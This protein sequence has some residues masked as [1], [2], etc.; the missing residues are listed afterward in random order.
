MKTKTEA[1][2]TTHRM[3]DSFVFLIAFPI[4]IYQQSINIVDLDIFSKFLPICLKQVNILVEK[5]G[6]IEFKANGFL[7]VFHV[8]VP[9]RQKP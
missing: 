3:H 9:L 2:T 5:N 7:F 4:S 6:L 8:Y 1:I